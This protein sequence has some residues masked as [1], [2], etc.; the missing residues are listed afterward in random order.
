MTQKRTPKGYWKEKRKTDGRCG[1]AAAV[2]RCPNCVDYSAASDLWFMTLS[3]IAVRIASV[4][5]SLRV[6]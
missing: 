4:S 3:A 1:E 2:A 5:F 6:S